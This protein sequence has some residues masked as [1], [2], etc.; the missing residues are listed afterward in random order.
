MPPPPRD[1]NIGLATIN[2]KYVHLAL[3]PRYLRNAAR[4]AGFADTWL[5]EFTLKTPVEDM[6]GELE[7][8]V[9][10]VL[11]FS[12]Y[13]WNRRETF[14]LI[15]RL[16]RRRPELVI[17]V[18]GPEVS[19]EAGPPTPWIDYVIGGE[20]E[21]KWVQCL[22]HIAAGRAP[23]AATLARWRHHEGDLPPLDRPPYLDEDLAGIEHRLAYIE[24]SRGCPYTCSFCLSA[25]DKQV[26]FFP[27]PVLKA[28]VARLIGAG[29]RR[30]KFLD[31]TF[32]LRR[33]RALEWFRYLSAFEGVE[34][35]FEIVGDLLDEAVLTFLDTVPPGR[36]QFEIGVQSADPAANAR[37]GRRQ[38]AE[39]LLARVARLSAAERVHIHADL[40]WG[41]PGETLADIQRGFETVLATR[42][43]ELQLGFLK[44]LPGAPI[45]ALIGPHGYRFQDGPPY[46]V[47]AHADLPERDVRALKRFEAAFAR[48][49]NS[50]RFRFTLARL[51]ALAPAWELFEALADEAGRGGPFPRPLALDERLRALLA[52]GSRW[53]PREELVDLLKLD[54]CFHHRARHVPA[55]LADGRVKEP[56]E[57][58]RVRKRHPGAAVAPFRHEIA[59]EGGWPRL[60]P[61]AA[62]VWYAFH[63][64]GAASGYFFRPRVEP[65]APAG[66][67]GAS[68][69]PPA[70]V[71]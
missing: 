35:H 59:W 32:N 20:G 46:E 48:F 40:I 45:R 25:L 1:L 44:F 50:G 14:A 55:F 71:A 17:V 49:Y 54:Y 37:V 34:F 10:D 30:I 18:G 12:V 47:I 31:R 9:P 51:L 33:G 3:A 4:A 64:P 24:T 41:L 58:R 70:A 5:R 67:A 26:R 68:G 23:D 57:I 19:F 56:P 60:T 6:A 16:K 28:E 2:A 39:T 61:G 36:F 63:Y 66:V 42:P 8:L 65:L 11:G 69:R 22:E 43:H 62:P 27:D 38:S 53:L 15:E 29:A 21:L 7:A 13:I 52:C